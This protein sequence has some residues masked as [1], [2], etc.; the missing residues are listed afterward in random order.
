MA[1][2][3]GKLVE[4]EQMQVETRDVACQWDGS[5]CSCRAVC[6]WFRLCFVMFVVC[7]YVF[8]LLAAAAD[9]ADAVAAALVCVGF[10]IIVVGCSGCCAAAPCITKPYQVLFLNNV[11]SRLVATWYSRSYTRYQVSIT[12]YLVPCT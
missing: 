9:A 1:G 3:N 7:F 8:I 10:C 6:T 4:E 11:L 12:L 5:E 2:G